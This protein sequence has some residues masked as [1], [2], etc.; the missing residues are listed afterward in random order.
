MHDDDGMLN[1]G[2]PEP[3]VTDEDE[4][5]L[6][7][8][9]VGEVWVNVHRFGGM[10]VVDFGG[11]VSWP[12][13]DGGEVST[14]SRYAVHAQCPFRIV[15]CGEVY[16]GSDDLVPGGGG[17]RLA[18][19][20]GADALREFLARRSPRVLSVERAPEGDLRITLEHELRIDVLPTSSKVEE[21]W[22]FVVRGGEHVVFPPVD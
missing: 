8:R 10:G 16:L 18:Y 6:L 11:T 13:G 21:C 12:L 14:G 2:E 19:D 3:D 1:N 22:R 7:Q 9:L 15:Q 4:D 17:D 5:E 20:T